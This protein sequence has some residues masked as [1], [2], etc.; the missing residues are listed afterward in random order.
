MQSRPYQR[1]DGIKVGDEVVLVRGARGRGP[2]S[3]PGC[4]RAIRA[5]YVGG[6]RFNVYCELLEDDP[7]AT[8]APFKS[9]E[10]GL[11]HGYSFIRA[12]GG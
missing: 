11:W 5:L 4:E 1:A 12:L 6:N 10:R 3:G 8:V 9:G 7:H 2:E